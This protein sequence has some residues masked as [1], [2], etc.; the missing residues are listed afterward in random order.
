MNRVHRC[1]AKS[2]GHAG[3]CL[4]LLGVNSAAVSTPA[5][6]RPSPPGPPFRRPQKAGVCWHVAIHV[7]HSDACVI[8]T[9]PHDS[10]AGKL[11][12]SVDR[13][14]FIFS[15][16][17]LSHHLHY[18]GEHH[19]HARARPKACGINQRAPRG[20]RELPPATLASM[21]AGTPAA[22]ESA[23]PT[24]EELSACRSFAA[25]ITCACRG[26]DACT[27]LRGGTG[28]RRA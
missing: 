7:R 19:A 13:L 25:S 17:L 18:H 1:P 27:L 22:G 6:G 23:P 4:A 14:S 8:L 12:C 15:I 11:A 24:A 10:H 16:L 9:L 3:R 2:A 20:S 21:S 26:R 28:S 5:L